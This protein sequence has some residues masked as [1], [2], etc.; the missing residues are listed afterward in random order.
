LLQYRLMIPAEHNFIKAILQGGNAYWWFAFCIYLFAIIHISFWELEHV[1]AGPVPYAG[2]L[3]CFV[4]ELSFHFSCNVFLNINCRNKTK[5]HIFNNVIQKRTMTNLDL[6][7]KLFSQLL[8]KE[9]YN[10]SHL[11]TQK[12]FITSFLFT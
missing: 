11:K 10:L 6:Y 2:H 5:S 1:V 7:Y 8:Y 4:S 9:N 12:Y 3:F